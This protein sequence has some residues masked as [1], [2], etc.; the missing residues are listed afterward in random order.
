MKIAIGYVQSPA[1]RAALDA[2]VQEAKA[3][4]AELLIVHTPRVGTSAEMRG[5]MDYNEEMA[6]VSARLEREGLRF[7]IGD[8]TQGD[9]PAEDLLRVAREEDVD[10]IVIGLRRRSPVGKLVLGSVS[11]DV[12]LG[13]ECPVLAVKAPASA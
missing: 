5:A 13:A 2:A 1:G 3:R 8:V 7:R 9:S 4:D 12:L 10:L 6:H 11:Q